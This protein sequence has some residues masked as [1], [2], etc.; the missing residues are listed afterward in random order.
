M[1][2]QIPSPRSGSTPS[3]GT[4]PWYQQPKAVA[5]GV[6]A[7]IF[8]ATAGLHL[9]A[10]VDP[11]VAATPPLP[12]ETAKFVAQPSFTW[13]DSFAG[14]IEPKRA[15]GVAFERAG[16]VT[17]VE[18]EEGAVV[19]EGDV[20]A[21]L[22]TAQLAADR[23]RLLAQLSQ[24]EAQ[25]E[26]A[27]LTAARQK[28]LADEGHSSEQRYDEARLNAE[29]LEASAQALAASIKRLDV[30]LE[31]S[32]LRA[33]FDGRVAARLIDEGTVIS[34]G[35][36]VAELLESGR[37]QARIG[38]P[39]EVAAEMSSGANFT[40][41]YSGRGIAATVATVRPDVITVTRTVPVLFDLNADLPV[42]DIIRFPY[43]R[44]S[45]VSGGWLP[46]SALAEAEKGLWSVYTAKEVDGEQI[47][48]RENVEVVHVEDQN[49]FVRGT[50]ADGA[51]VLT[52]GLNRVV[53][54]QPITATADQ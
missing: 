34:A 12:V 38:L 7:L 29:A 37:I 6:V 31:K 53:P 43:P 33:P 30:D 4:F 3:A 39:P 10:A 17:S 46:I 45:T 9:R 16:K 2:D 18:V 40:F 23:T 27:L 22:D 42:G 14:F 52:R 19:R 50:L 11:G 25:A 35:T 28:V 1:A 51:R 13:T 21:V 26:L 8:V 48:G 47:V 5:L 15:T 32:T 41:D 44:T 36:A 20:L 54:G 24:T 49:V